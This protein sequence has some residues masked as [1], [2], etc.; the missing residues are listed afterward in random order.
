VSGILHPMNRRAV[1]ALIAPLAV[2]ACGQAFTSA[3][4]DGGAMPSAEASLDT[5]AP[6]PDGAPEDAAAPGDAASED[7]TTR[8]AT[9]EDGGHGEGDASTGGGDGGPALPDAA[10]CL[11]TCPA[12]FDC[13]EGKCEDRAALHFSATTNRPFNW[14]YGYAASPA[15]TFLPDPSHFSPA[16]GLDIWTASAA[17]GLE[18]SVFH[19]GGPVTQT[20]AE[21][22][23]P[24]AG[25]GIYP[26]PNG[27]PSIIRWTA[28]AA[29]SYA[30][31]VT[32]TGIS[33]P[34]TAVTASVLVN[35][36]SEMGSSE[37]LNDYGGTNT[38]TYSVP[39]Q[40]LAAGGFIDFFVTMVV[41]RDDAPGGTTVDAR[42]T[43]E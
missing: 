20:Y 29:G 9:P 35:N 10:L 34:A 33:T 31:D 11:R 25:L 41:N 21:M 18:P 17:D 32:F 22:A 3:T 19:N 16:A 38:F 8:D 37:A 13:L 6:G 42:I 30:I 7:A 1:S 23:I 39:A 40:P 4:G 15:G 5:G 14:S 28:P 36:T 2:A 24:A 12:G 43:A 26:G 27:E